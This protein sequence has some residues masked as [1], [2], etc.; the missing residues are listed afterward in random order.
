MFC[1]PASVV[2]LAVAL[3]QLG[4]AAE[5]PAGITRSGVP[6]GEPVWLDPGAVVVT[7]P[8]APAAFSVDRGQGQIESAKD[9]AQDFARGVLTIPPTHPVAGVLAGGASVVVAPFAALTGSASA[10]GRRLD[11]VALTQ[12]EQK[13]QNAIAAM[14]AQR[15]LRDA[16]LKAASTQSHRRFLPVQALANPSSPTVTVSALLESKLEELR[17]ERTGKGDES[18]ALRMKARA[19]VVRASDG[20]VLYDE[21]FEYL[22]GTGLFLDWSLGSSLQN[23][24]DTGYR[25]LAERMTE[26][27]FLATR[28]EP[29]LVGAGYRK[30]YT[31]TPAMPRQ[32]Q[33]AAAPMPAAA[34]FTPVAYRV[35]D[36]GAI[37]IYSTSSVPQLVIQ[38]PLT[39]NQAV[40]AARS[41]IA[42]GHLGELIGFPNPVVSALALGAAI[43][44][45][46]F[47]HQAA[48]FNGLTEQRF[49]KADAQVTVAIRETRAHEAIAFAVAQQLAPHTSQTVALVKKPQ[50][51]G[52]LHQAALLQFPVHGTL[53]ALP[54][55]VT[56]VNYLVSQGMSKALEI[57]VTRA[58]LK[59]NG[60]V[61]P[62]LAL[63][64]EATAT[65]RRTSDGQTLYSCPVRYQGR[66]RKFTEWSEHDAKL[67]RDEMDRCHQELGQTIVTQLVARKVLPSKIGNEPLL[68]TTQP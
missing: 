50:P 39:K 17:L 4:H 25:K 66:A 1:R 61:N 26:C 9:R 40:E 46:L 20:K 49:A 12:V 45:G 28:D 29:A 32:Q 13:L 58:V 14:A 55:G 15:H 31:P 68:A 43:P 56:P 65:L 34:G 64:L 36:L 24:A 23:V 57:H 18:F 41:D 7:A 22:S 54:R 60:G 27:L 6:A 5:R 10:S 30:P 59:G 52:D 44:V 35:A 51:T 48:M 38:A 62:P 37:G 42:D 63:H 2:I 33:V 8:D 67:L 21:P 19:R 16:L 47:K 53:G 3:L 11:S